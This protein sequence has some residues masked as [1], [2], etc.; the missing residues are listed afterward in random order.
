MI[1]TTVFDQLARVAI[2]QCLLWI[3]IAGT[4]PGVLQYILQAL[5]VGRF[6]LGAVFVGLTQ[7]EFN[8]SC[9]ARSSVAVVAIITVAADAVAL[10]GLFVKAITSGIFSK[11][12]NGGN[13]SARGKATIAVLVGLGIW[14]GVSHNPWTR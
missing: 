5:V 11:I 9:V 6:I 14:I 2:E 1:F 4:K 12:E 3:I 8:T 10:V 13:S 7:S